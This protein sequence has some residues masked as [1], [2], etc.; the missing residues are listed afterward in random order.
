MGENRHLIEVLYKCSEYPKGAKNKDL[1]LTCR[2][3][4]L[5]SHL[6]IV[7]GLR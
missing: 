1:N 7:S 4:S 5:L 2:I 3:V 6:L